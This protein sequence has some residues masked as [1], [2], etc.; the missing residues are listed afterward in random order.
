MSRVGRAMCPPK[1]PPLLNRAMRRILRSRLSRLVDRGVMLVTVSGRHT[2]RPYTLPVQYVED[3]DVVWILVG[4]SHHKTWWRNLVDGGRVDLVMRGHLRQ[5][6][7]Q[8]HTF[9]Q[10]PAVVKEG[11]HRYAQRFPFMARGLGVRNGDED[12]LARAAARTAVVRIHL[13]AADGLH[14]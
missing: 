12:S 1:R 6:R 3:G 8:A 5:G 7:G 4:A 13:D 9:D 14:G 2:G 10:H 11:L